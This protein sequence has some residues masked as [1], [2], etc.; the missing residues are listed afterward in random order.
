MG[1]RE[2][3]LHEK[4]AGILKMPGYSE[5]AVKERIDFIRVHDEDMVNFHI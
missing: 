3:W 2:G 5:E 4:I 1:L